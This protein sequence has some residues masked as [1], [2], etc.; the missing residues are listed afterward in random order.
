MRAWILCER[1]VVKIEPVPNDHDRGYRDCRE[2]MR[3]AP[4]AKKAAIRPMAGIIVKRLG[5]LGIS[6]NISP[7]RWRI[8][9]RKATWAPGAVGG[10][11]KR[12]PSL[13]RLL[14][15]NQ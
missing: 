1:L 3:S 8:A 11:F 15:R 14:R 10:S 12:N 7:R 2:S 5:L 6:D 4:A 9:R 13:C